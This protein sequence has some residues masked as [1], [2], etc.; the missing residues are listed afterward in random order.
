MPCFIRLFYFFV[1]CRVQIDK[2][3]N[4]FG[5]VTTQN[6]SLQE[7][8]ISDDKTKIWQERGL[9]ILVEST[10]PDAIALDESKQLIC[11]HRDGERITHDSLIIKLDLAATEQLNPQW[12]F[13]IITQ[14]K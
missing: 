4:I 11:H 12:T 6:T 10:E 1:V 3:K 8:A 9:I 7:Q 13:E 14:P 2:S 5:A